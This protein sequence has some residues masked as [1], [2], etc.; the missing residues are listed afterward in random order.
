MIELERELTKLQ[1]SGRQ[2]KAIIFDDEID[3]DMVPPLADWLLLKE[4]LGDIEADL[5][6]YLHQKDHNVV[7]PPSV[8]LIADAILELAPP[9][10]S[11]AARALEQYASYQP[12]LSKLKDYLERY[13]FDVTCSTGMPEINPQ[14]MPLLCL[15]DYQILPQGDDGEMAIAFFKRL[16]KIASEEDLPP[17][18]VFLMSKA[19]KDDDANKWSRLAEAGGLFRFNYGFLNKEKFDSNEL[20]LAYPLLHHL[21]HDTLSVA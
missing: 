6:G 13:G 10:G 19:L 1:M 18:Y 15:V 11:G 20:H 3:F 14:E 12:V 16:M 21:K 9:G 7:D 17:P 5:L 8:A 4:E 2:L